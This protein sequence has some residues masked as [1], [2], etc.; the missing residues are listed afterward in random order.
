M[1]GEILS[2]KVPAHCGELVEGN[3]G[4]HHFLASYGVD[5]Y[6]QVS[7]Q[8]GQTKQQ[9]NGDKSRTLLA[10]MEEQYGISCEGLS[11]SMMSEIPVGKGMASSSAD[12][13]GLIVALNEWFQLNLSREEMFKILTEIEPSDSNL[14][15]PLTLID[16]MQGDILGQFL[17]VSEMDLLILLLDEEIDTYQF[18]QKNQYKDFITY[19]TL[20]SDFINACQSQNI[21]RIAEL[22]YQSAWLS[23]VKYPYLESFYKL[24]KHTGFFGL[25]IAHSG[26]TLSLWYDGEILPRE[27]L[28]ALVNDIDRDHLYGCVM[29]QRI[30]NTGIQIEWGNNNA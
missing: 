26:T 4:A 23:G 15:A 8:Q 27:N 12:L 7:I 3:D 6:S 14:L 20:L 1:Q 19:Q 9:L 21:S 11:L 28:E 16:F 13:S 24:R 29:P 2:V 5:L 18:Y 25:N 17:A 22:A 30:T 10:S